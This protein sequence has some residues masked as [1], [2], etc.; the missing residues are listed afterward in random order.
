M[1]LL[2]GRPVPRAPRPELPRPPREARP[3]NPR[4]KA[5]SRSRSSNQIEADE[6][7]TPGHPAA[8]AVEIEVEAIPFHNRSL[9]NQIARGSR[10]PE[11]EAG[12]ALKPCKKCVFFAQLTSNYH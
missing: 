7:R 3:I 9:R 12:T 6:A 1:G 10:T 11:P 4:A 5:R 2:N 8:S